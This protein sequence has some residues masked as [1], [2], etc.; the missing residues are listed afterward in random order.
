MTEEDNPQR[1]SGDGAGFLSKI[2]PGDWLTLA[3]LIIAAFVTWNKMDLRLS[4]LEEITA[5]QQQTNAKLEQAIK[6]TTSDLRSDIKEIS[7][8]VRRVETQVMRRG[9]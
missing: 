9:G 6:E 5:Q 3:S 4:R 2:R 1:R 8:S 7:T